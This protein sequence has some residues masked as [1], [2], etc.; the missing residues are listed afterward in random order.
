MYNGEVSVMEKFLPTVIKTAEYLEVK[1]LSITNFNEKEMGKVCVSEDKNFNSNINTAFQ[2][3]SNKH[4]F[5]FY[6]TYDWIIE[7]FFSIGN[8]YY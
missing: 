4:I 7:T 8:N 1:G 5:K 2:N 6:I 3:V